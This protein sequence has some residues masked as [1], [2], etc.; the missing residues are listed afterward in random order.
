MRLPHLPTT[1]LILLVLLASL[2][3]CNGPLAMIPGGAFQGATEATTPGEW[4]AL[5]DGVLELET[6][7]DD[8][9][10]VEINYVVR[11]G[12]LYIDPAEGRGWLK[13]LRADPRVRVRIGGKI[14]AMQASLV[15]D[16]TERADFAADRFVY[17]LNPRSPG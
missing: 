14:Y 5:Q 9:Y 7:P 3:G 10:S 11:N 16:P 13:N 15:D 1:L 2:G 6:R 4:S 12:H 8:P 17:R